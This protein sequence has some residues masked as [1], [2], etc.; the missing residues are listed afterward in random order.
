MKFRRTGIRLLQSWTSISRHMRN[1]AEK[2]FS[3][4][5]P[6]VVLGV[7]TT[8]LVRNYRDKREKRHRT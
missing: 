7:G 1:L 2:C 6:K 3:A 4:N 8:M 5:V